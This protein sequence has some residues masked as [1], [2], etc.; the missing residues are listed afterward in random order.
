MAQL[1]ADLPEAIANTV[2]I[3]KRCNLELELGKRVPA[4][5]SL[6]EDGTRRARYL[7]QRARAGLERAPCR[8]A[9]DSG[10][11][12]PLSRAARARAR[13]DRARWASRA[14]S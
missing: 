14:I 7:K 11:A 2:E 10:A 1:F 5:I 3:A 8:A 9:R 13:V 6:P 12:G 4:G